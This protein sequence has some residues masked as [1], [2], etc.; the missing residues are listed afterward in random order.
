MSEDVSVGPN[1]VPQKLVTYEGAPSP[2]ELLESCVIQA[3]AALKGLKATSAK[4]DDRPSNEDEMSLSV[5]QAAQR[6][7]DKEEEQLQ[8]ENFKLMTFWWVPKRVDTAN[9][10]ARRS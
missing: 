3:Q 10:V 7:M 8:D 2:R 6:D 5:A 1:E 9:P 4:P